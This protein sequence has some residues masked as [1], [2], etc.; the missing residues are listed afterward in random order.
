[1]HSSHQLHCKRSK[2]SAFLSN[3]KQFHHITTSQKILINKFK[4]TELWILFIWLTWEYIIVNF[5]YTTFP[6]IQNCEFC[7][8]DLPDNTE[9]WILF[10][11]LTWEYRIVKFV[12]Q[13]FLWCCNMMELFRIAKECRKLWTFTMKLRCCLEQAKGL[14]SEFQHF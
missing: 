4:N 3:S 5:V 6:R 2:F 12:D 10:I 14:C 8:Y 11:R 9:L 1:V 13:Y 7:L